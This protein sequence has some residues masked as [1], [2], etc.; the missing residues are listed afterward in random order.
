MDMYSSSTLKTIDNPLIERRLLL[1]IAMRGKWGDN[2]IVVLDD[3]DCYLLTNKQV[4]EVLRLRRKI[5]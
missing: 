2:N 5:G 1:A 4:E 3:S